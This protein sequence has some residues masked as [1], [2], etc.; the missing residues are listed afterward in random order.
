MEKS[1]VNHKSVLSKTKIPLMV[2]GEKLQQ[3]KYLSADNKERPA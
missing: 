2:L 1:Y 3:Y